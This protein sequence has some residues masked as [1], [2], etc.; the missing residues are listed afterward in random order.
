[1]LMAYSSSMNVKPLGKPSPHP[2]ASDQ[3]NCP[4]L[5]PVS[6]QPW[7]TRVSLSL[8]MRVWSW[9][10]LACLFWKLLEMRAPHLELR[11][12]PVGSLGLENCQGAFCTGTG[13]HIHTQARAHAGAHTW[14]LAWF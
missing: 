8:V 4:S 5:S 12:L 9:T 1:M 7:V 11:I 6:P 2:P 3:A 14:I 10:S 13:T